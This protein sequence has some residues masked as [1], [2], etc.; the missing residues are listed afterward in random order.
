MKKELNAEETQPSRTHRVYV[1]CP[2][3]LF[4]IS[5]YLY[6]ILYLGFFSLF[7]DLHSSLF[8]CFPFFIIFL[9]S[10]LWRGGL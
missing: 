2:S 8:R 1:S 10:S 5:L 4:F 7:Q 3:S 9:L 6:V